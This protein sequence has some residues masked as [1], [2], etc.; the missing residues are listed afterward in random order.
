MTKEQLDKLAHDLGISDEEVE[1]AR[2]MYEDYQALKSWAGTAKA[3]IACLV[4]RQ[5][6][7]VT[8]QIEDLNKLI[9]TYRYHT[10]ADSEGSL[11]LYLKAKA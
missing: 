3:I 1:E 4:E 8:I 10:R 2:T 11:T 5:G 7:S 9:Q 6:G